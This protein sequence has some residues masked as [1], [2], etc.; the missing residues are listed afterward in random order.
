MVTEEINEAL[1]SPSS[2]WRWHTK[3]C[4]A[5]D[6]QLVRLMVTFVGSRPMLS[7][8]A[9]AEFIGELTRRNRAA[10]GV[11]DDAERQPRRS[12]G[13]ERLLKKAGLLQGDA[14][15]DRDANDAASRPVAA[16]GH[17]AAE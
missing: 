6:G 5:R 9:V 12:P 11:G 17:E 14:G 10:D 15:A 16:A 2:L 3:G 8:E 1:I 7:R 13:T 4:R